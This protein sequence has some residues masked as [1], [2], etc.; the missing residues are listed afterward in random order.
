MYKDSCGVLKYIG[1]TAH[2]DLPHETRLPALLP[3]NHYL[4]MLLVRDAHERVHHNK[5]EATKAKFGTE[6]G[7]SRDDTLLKET[8]AS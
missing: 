7:F 1:R 5:V 4:S 2:A 6:F 3:K 8:L